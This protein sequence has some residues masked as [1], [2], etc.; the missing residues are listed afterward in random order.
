[1]VE[2]R[3]YR[4]ARKQD[5][6]DLCVVDRLV[7]TGNDEKCACLNLQSITPVKIQEKSSGL[8]V[9]TTAYSDSSALYTSSKTIS[10]KTA[11]LHFHCS[12]SRLSRGTIIF[13]GGTLMAKSSF[14]GG[15]TCKANSDG[16][17]LVEIANALG[18]TDG[19]RCGSFICN[20]IR[21]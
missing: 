2:N 3:A 15:R 1:M 9:L 12:N 17:R 7:E 20:R 10:Q 11:L 16:E 4:N 5:T 6:L 18:G 21:P 8:P 13:C 14:N 19:S